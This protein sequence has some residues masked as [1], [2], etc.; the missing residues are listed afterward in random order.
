MPAC[1]QRSLTAN[2]TDRPTDGTT[3][4]ADAATD[5][6]A[7]AT[8]CFPGAFTGRV[9]GTIGDSSFTLDPTSL[10]ND[11]WPVVQESWSILRAAAGKQVVVAWG[12]SGPDGGTQSNAGA[13]LLLPD[14]STSAP[15][16]YCAA[17]VEAELTSPAPDLAVAI[18]LSELS[19]LGQCPG[20]PVSGNVQVCTDRG[21][22]T[23]GGD[24][25]CAQ[26]FGASGTVDGITIDIH[27]AG[28]VVL[29]GAGT[30]DSPFEV[31]GEGNADG[32]ILVDSG[33]DG[34]ISGW[35]RVPNDA[36]PNAGT[37]FCLA[38][39]HLTELAAHVY[40]VSFQSY[41]RLGQCPGSPIDGT[42]NL[43]Q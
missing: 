27:S 38:E 15:T 8:A 17:R 6:P 14:A 1:G 24:G 10:S 19:V 40:S 3:G 39:G 5:G 23:A 4:I 32:L 25:A 18:T 35:L 7:A 41:S 22:P 37:I 12:E 33:A 20:A 42:V 36:G 43:C 9:T 13:V 34:S 30:P 2:A 29:A 11:G 16:F 26:G 31:I 21:P 28:G